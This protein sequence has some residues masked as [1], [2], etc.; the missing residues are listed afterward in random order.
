MP[1]DRP[2][3][4]TFAEAMALL[5]NNRM[6]HCTAE[7]L[8]TEMEAQRHSNLFVSPSLAECYPTSAPQ[9]AS[10]QSRPPCAHDH[11]GDPLFSPPSR[12]PTPKNKS[13]ASAP[14]TSTAKRSKDSTFTCKVCIRS[15]SGDHFYERHLQ[16]ISCQMAINS[17]ARTVKVAHS[18][19]KRA[20]IESINTLT[21]DEHKQLESHRNNIHLDAEQ[22]LMRS[23]P[24]AVLERSP[25][26]KLK[27]HTQYIK[28]IV[29]RPFPNLSKSPTKP[30][31]KKQSCHVAASARQERHPDRMS[32]YGSCACNALGSHH[33]MLMLIKACEDDLAKLD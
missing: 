19:A 23:C 22:R 15:L 2:N 4:V 25:R 27:P 21:I 29:K 18:D 26:P 30:S 10:P 14:S 17:V 28:G 13:Q 24:H 1:M 12:T 3:T 8:G 32:S 6:Q 11:P 7:S 9:C 31:P 20:Y 16:C 33:G 5:A